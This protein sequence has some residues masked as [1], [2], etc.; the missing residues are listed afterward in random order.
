MPVPI[1]SL[2]ATTRATLAVHTSLATG[3]P[4]RLD[5]PAMTVAAPNGTHS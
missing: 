3:V 2:V 1:G 5:A 4:V